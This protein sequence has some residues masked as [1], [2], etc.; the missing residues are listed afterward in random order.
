[1]LRQRQGTSPARVARGGSPAAED[2]GGIAGAQGA[3]AA[4]AQMQGVGMGLQWAAQP[5][6]WSQ[7]SRLWAGLQACEP[8]LTTTWKQMT[9]GC[10]VRFVLTTSHAPARFCSLSPRKPPPAGAS[11]CVWHA[12]LLPARR[13]PRCSRLHLMSMPSLPCAAGTLL[14]VLSRSTICLHMS[15]DQP[16][17]TCICPVAGTLCPGDRPRF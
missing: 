10:E 3:R 14:P 5:R 1:M 15:K 7:G 17:T 16:C 6:C 4:P 2:A 9:G 11:C 12:M 13:R 8:A